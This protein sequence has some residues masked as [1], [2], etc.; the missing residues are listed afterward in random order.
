MTGEGC[1]PYIDPSRKGSRSAVMAWWWQGTRIQVAPALA[2]GDSTETQRTPPTDSSVQAAVCLCTDQFAS[3]QAEI[4]LCTDQFASV[5]ADVCLC[6]D[7]FASV[8]AEICLCTDQLASVQADVCLCTDQLASVQAE[9]CLCTDQLASVQAE[10]CLCTD[11]FASVQ[12][13]ISRTTA[14]TSVGRIGTWQGFITDTV[15]DEK[16]QLARHCQAFGWMDSSRYMRT[17]WGALR[18]GYTPSQHS[19]I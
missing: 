6:T 4:C 14:P 17:P 5:Q 2:H 3:V 8:Q 1:D 16:C 9:I 11:Q 19:P 15:A 13:E 12:A 7:Q 10:I 18:G